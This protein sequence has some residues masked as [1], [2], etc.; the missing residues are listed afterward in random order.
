[1]EAHE[2]LLNVTWDGKNGEMTDPVPF[3]A[4]DGDLKQMAAEAVRAGDIDGI[5]ADGGVNFGDF[6]VDRFAATGDLPNRLMI[7]PKTPFGG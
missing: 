1:M 3:D 5:G 6:V 7:R 2:A 4:A